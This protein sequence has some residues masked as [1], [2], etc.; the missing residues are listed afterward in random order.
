MKKGFLWE[1]L[2]RRYSV[3]TIVNMWKHLGQCQLP[4]EG[5]FK[6]FLSSI[7]WRYC[8][9]VAHRV[10][11]MTQ[12]TSLECSC[13]GPYPTF[14]WK[15]DPAHCPLAVLEVS[16]QTPSHSTPEPLSPVPS[17]APSLLT[18][19]CVSQIPQGHTWEFVISQAYSS[20][21]TTWPLSLF[22]QLPYSM[23]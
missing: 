20:L 15:G 13:A 21:V 1:H 14:T 10:E 16:D 12:K 19:L 17:L 6:V 8:C 9:P 4:G 2:L 23:P 22:L 11:S 5:S 7:H 3:G 18:E